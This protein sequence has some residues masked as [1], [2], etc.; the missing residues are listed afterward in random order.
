MTHPTYCIYCWEQYKHL[1]QS[2]EPVLFLVVSVTTLMLVLDLF[3]CTAMSGST[4]AI[5]LTFLHMLLINTALLYYLCLS[6]EDCYSHFKSVLGPLRLLF[7]F[8]IF[9]FHVQKTE[10]IQFFTAKHI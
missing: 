8:Y 6:A 4:W 9:L 2:L 5:S 10:Q 3:Y 1:R 7:L